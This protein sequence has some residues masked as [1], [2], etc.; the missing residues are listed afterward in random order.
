[1]TLDSTHDTVTTSA[2]P[3][4]FTVEWSIDVT[5]TDHEDAARQAHEIMR[6]PTSLATVFDVR[7]SEMGDE[8]YLQVDLEQLEEV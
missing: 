8:T 7:E 3:R 2:A 5:A 1:M 6:D 4:G